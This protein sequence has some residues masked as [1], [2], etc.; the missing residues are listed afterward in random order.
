[1]IKRK[2]RN[3]NCQQCPLWEG[4]ETVCL[5]GKG[6]SS[7]LMVILEAP[8]T[9][10]DRG[11]PFISGHAGKMFLQLLE[12]AGIP[13]PF[14]THAVKCKP[15]DGE[16]PSSA[17]LKACKDYL[18]KEIEQRQPQWILTLGAGALKYDAGIGVGRM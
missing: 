14:V 4:A 15:A 16:S 7:P 5:M 6:P 9:Q 18:I 17:E 10:A 13:E 8:G 3:S 11:G 12:D 2:I 1:M